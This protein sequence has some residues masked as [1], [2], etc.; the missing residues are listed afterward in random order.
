M[1]RSKDMPVVHHLR[2]QRDLSQWE[3]A[4]ALGVSQATIAVWER[5]YREPSPGQIQQLA[6]LYRV[7]ERTIRAAL[8]G[9]EQ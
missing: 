7:A 5:G 2:Q 3:V 1:R 4:Q 6:V 9:K 8:T